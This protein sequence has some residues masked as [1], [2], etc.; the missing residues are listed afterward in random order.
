MIRRWILSHKP[1]GTLEYREPFVGG[2]GVF[3]GLTATAVERRWINDKHPGLMAVY[4]ALAERPEE[5][6]AA[7]KSIAAAQPGESVT[8]PGVRGGRPKNARLAALFQDVCLN[9]SCDQALRYFFVN[10]T[11][12]GSGRVNY[13]L[14]SRLYFS[15]EEGWGIVETDALERAA[16]LIHGTKITCDDYESLFT[17][18]GERVWIY[19]DPPYVVNSNLTASSQ[20]YQH[21]FT[22]ADHR[23]FAAVAAACEHLL[24]ISYDDDEEGFIRSLYSADRFCI[25]PA[26]WSYM[27]TTQKRKR[28]GRELL[29]MNYDPQGVGHVDLDHG[30]RV[31]G[32]GQG[33]LHLPIPG[34]S[35]HAQC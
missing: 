1:A 6:I 23:R 16:A 28:V 29:I 14:P 17:E 20:L 34:R 8:P 22:H 13:D 27:G 10:R 12:H 7:C 30:R 9:E 5:F 24:C 26:S 4:Q 31:Q 33:L 25:V 21:G 18:P 15:N 11:V 3:F 35:N 32:Y 2:G 19:A